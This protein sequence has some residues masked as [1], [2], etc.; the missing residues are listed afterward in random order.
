MMN[1]DY[2]PSYKV[3]KKLEK[4]GLRD[5]MYGGFYVP[6][7]NGYCIE[8]LEYYDEDG[9]YR[10]IYNPAFC[11]GYCR[12]NIIY[13]PKFQEI[14]EFIEKQLKFSVKKV[15]EG[16]RSITWSF[17]EN[18][19]AGHRSITFSMKDLENDSVDKALMIFLN[20]LDTT[21]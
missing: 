10:T 3:A 17:V 20:Y 14:Q 8:S 5:S 12:D 7:Q 6:F 4:L 21:K 16:S 9:L 1:N 19:S 11:P 15:K 2:R 18:S 13:A